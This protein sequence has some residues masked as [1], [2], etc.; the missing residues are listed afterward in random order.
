[1]CQNGVSHDARAKEVLLRYVIDRKFYPDDNGCSLCCGNDTSPQP[2]GAL[3]LV[4][5]DEVGHHAALEQT[6]LRLHSDLEDVCGIG[7]GGG[8]DSRHDAAEDVDDHGLVFWATDKQP[9]QRIVG[10]YL[11]CP[12]RSLSQQGGRNPRVECPDA[13][14]LAN[15]EE[16]VEH[17]SVAHLCILGL[18]LDL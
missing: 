2:S 1:M 12:I 14:L 4:D 10:S 6:A 15:S 16:G 11:D 17:A 18:T 3:C 9:L 7:Q 8:Q 5:V 13:L